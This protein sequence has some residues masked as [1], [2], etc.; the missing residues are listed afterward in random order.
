VAANADTAVT[1]LPVL[2]EAMER[3]LATLAT[4]VAKAEHHADRRE[5]RA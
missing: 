1:D 5:E 2:R 3:E 4:A